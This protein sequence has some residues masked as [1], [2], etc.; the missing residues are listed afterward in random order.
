[1]TQ[2]KSEDR[3]VP[4]GGVMPV[5]R[6][7]SSPGGQGKAVPVEETA[8]QLCLPIAT[9]E[10]LRGAT[11]RRSRD[12]LGDIRAE[13]S[14]AIGKT[15][16]AASATMEEVAFRLTDALLKVASN[17]GAP[18]P[19]GQ[20]I[21]ALADQWS[22]VLPRLQA[23]LLQGR[24]QPGG[25]R[26]VFIPKAG[27]GQRGLGIPDVIDRIVQEAVRQVLEPLWEPTF[28]PSNHGFRTGRS[29]H[30]AIA[31]A[32][33][34]VE[35]GHEWCVDLDLEKFFDLVCHQR[36]TARLAERVGDRRLLGLIGRML[37]AKVVLPDGVVIDTE[38]GVPQGGPLSPLLSNVVLDEL[39]RELDRRGHRFVRYADDAKVYVRS[40]RAGRRVMA[41]LTEF[42][43]GRLR[44][45]VNEAKSAVARP[46]DR[47][48]LGFCLRVDPQS[49]AVE[50]LL[51][52][53]TKRNAMQR[54][55]ELTP[56]NWGNTL[57]ACISQINAW[58][59]GWHGFFGIASESEMQ[60]MRKIDAHLRR[61]LR[62]IILRH[63]KRKRTI[64]RNL[65]KLGV[66]RQS[67]WRQVYQGRR[68]W[69]ALSH[70]PAVDHG[71]NR[72]FFRERGLVALVEM[73][74]QASQHISAPELPQLA[75]WG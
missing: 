62:A 66:P 67:A 32:K 28:H 61:R 50:V 25:I 7:G 57:V 72:A 47:H 8:V 52:E 75:L 49:G 71:L 1:M 48:F 46:E 22:V 19:D 23:D 3:V 26:R 36:L 34:H 37:R 2:Q 53:R 63:W 43:E 60:M 73:Y 64:A 55:R 41:S 17:K 69:W 45:K 14:K 30:T 18:G 39:D 54:V 33:T 15:G 27:G 11:R 12:R 16:M 65:I 5:E 4:E 59:Q 74:R 44:L 58:V 29:C 9:A 13:A 68:S 56:R 20:T 35:D 38:Q 10:N 6:A 24:Y 51:S 42:I 70:I 40:E 21:E 31:E